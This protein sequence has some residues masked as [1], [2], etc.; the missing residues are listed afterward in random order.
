LL[1]ETDF[2]DEIV[3]EGEAETPGFA[4]MVEAALDRRRLLRKLTQDRA[5]LG[6]SQTAVAA[7]MGTSQSAIA[8][9]ESG[10]ADIRMSTVE[11]YAATLGRK[12]EWR[13]A[14]AGGG[15]AAVRKSATGT[16]LI[17]PG[18]VPSRQ[19]SSAHFSEG[20]IPVAFIFSAPGEKEL[21]AGKPVAGETGVNLE[22][23]LQHLC[24]ARPKLFPSAHRYDYRITN[25]WP[26]PI[27]V[28]LGHRGSQASD[29]EVR[30][31]RNVE[32]VLRELEGCKLVVLSGGKARLL[33]GALRQS[34]RTVVE[35]PHVGN[36]G[37]NVSFKP[38][39]W[40][41][42]SAERR[43]RRVEMWAGDVLEAVPA[44]AERS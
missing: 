31:A 12:V 43:A 8:R 39:P 44:K 14:P 1:D 29:G 7:S 25:A 22:S 32:R 33:A 5:E 30:D 4:L 11:R 15:V 38:S 35:V 27:A 34:G 36:K 37:L 17:R 26:E 6:L 18:T 21:R 23:A 42:S 10:T 24:E 13:V 41:S 20:Q 19:R 9:L 3:S 16:S 2:L 40:P 28:A